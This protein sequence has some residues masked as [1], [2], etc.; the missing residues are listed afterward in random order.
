M[1]SLVGMPEAQ[2]LD[3]FCRALGHGAKI[4]KW[5][6]LVLS[7]YRQGAL[8]SLE[9]YWQDLTSSEPANGLAGVLSCTKIYGINHSSAGNFSSSRLSVLGC[10]PQKQPL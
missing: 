4:G 2:P 7:L 1:S 3:S 8:A 5:G 6:G 9:S 10:A